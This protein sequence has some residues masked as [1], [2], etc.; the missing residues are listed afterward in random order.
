MITLLLLLLV[1]V[2]VLVVF[3]VVVLPRLVQFDRRPPGGANF[4]Y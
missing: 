4:H 3:V 1:V 2:L